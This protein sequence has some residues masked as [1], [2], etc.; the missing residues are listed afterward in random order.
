MS[1]IS[2]DLSGKIDPQTVDALRAVR[3]TADVLGIPFFLVGASA[4]DFIMNHCYGI[5]TKRV[6]RDMDLAI[7]VAAWNHFH[8]FRKALTGTGRFTPDNREPQR[9]HFGSV[10]VDIVPFGPIA[11]GE[12]KIAWPPEN[13][14]T[15]SLLGFKE[16]YENSI[17]VRISPAPELDIQLPTLPALAVMKIIS[18][19]EKYPARK[20][21]AEDLL[22][23]MQ[24]YEN[25]GNFDR[26]YEEEPVLLE[27]EEFDT[28]LA[29]IR[30]LG[31][32][33]GRIAEPETLKVIKRILDHEMETKTPYRLISDMVMVGHG[34][35]YRFN[36]VLLQVAKLKLG[37]SENA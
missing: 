29:G 30:L 14:M 11:D 1:N 17:T 2:F 35:E 7:E 10:P 4:R 27:E 22:L 15:M 13:A 37:L 28:T 5:E 31:R 20:K 3:E 8:E 18:W 21:D 26:L 16:A 34:F 36:E 6:T 19:D 9:L 23:I 25:A 33:M 12:Q 32:D 24:N